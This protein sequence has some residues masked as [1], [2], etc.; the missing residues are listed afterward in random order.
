MAQVINF[1]PNALGYCHIVCKDCEGNEFHVK[2]DEIEG[3]PVFYALVCCKC[4]NEIFLEMTPIWR[5]G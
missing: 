1:K 5:K 4:K 2:A 3:M